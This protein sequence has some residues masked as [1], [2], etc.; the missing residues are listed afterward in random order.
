MPAPRLVVEVVSPSQKNRKRDLVDKRKQ[1]AERGI[2][3][4]WLI[5]AEN[6]C[7]MVLK[8]VDRTHSEHDVFRG[9]D[10]VDSPTLGLLQVTAEQIL[11]AGE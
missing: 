10:R 3:E 7:I 9:S 11:R 8:L 4:Y 5:D 1:Y 2:F 6:Q